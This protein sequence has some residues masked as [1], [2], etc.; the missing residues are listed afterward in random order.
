MLYNVCLTNFSL[1][2]TMVRHAA[3]NSLKWPRRPNLTSSS[4]P[5]N[6]ARHLLFNKLFSNMYIWWDLQ[7]PTASS[8]LGGQTWPHPV[9]HLG[10]L[11]NFCLIN[12]SLKCTVSPAEAH[13]VLLL[14]GEV[15]LEVGVKSNLA[16]VTPSKSLYKYAKLQISSLN[17]F[18]VYREQTDKQTNK[19]TENAVLY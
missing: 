11:Y 3:S 1:K 5:C 4:I 16:Y 7:P 6:D 13:G 17:S 15:L 18:G 14:A 19:R 8:G 9:Y 10:V 12:F 2:C